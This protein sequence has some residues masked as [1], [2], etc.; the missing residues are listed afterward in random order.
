MHNAARASSQNCAACANIWASIST[1]T[2]DL[3]REKCPGQACVR[4]L[5]MLLDA[6]WLTAHLL[7]IEGGKC[8]CPCKLCVAFEFRGLA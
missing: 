7:T 2:A 5:V 4:C 8:E 6:Q 3:E 1:H